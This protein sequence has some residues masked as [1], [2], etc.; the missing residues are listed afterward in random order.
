MDLAARYLSD[1][2]HTHTDARTLTPNEH[3]R[4]RT[5]SPKILRPPFFPWPFLRLHL[6]FV[7]L[8]KKLT[9]GVIRSFIFFRI[10]LLF[11]CI[12]ICIFCLVA[13]LFYIFIFSQIYLCWSLQDPGPWLSGEHNHSRHFWNHTFPPNKG[14]MSSGISSPNQARRK[15][16][17]LVVP[18][19]QRYDRQ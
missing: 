1:L 15:Q 17:C 5:H 13:V 3:A 2:T 18:T 6:S 7:T 19:F 14:P 12:V 16:I 11:F 4:T 9:C 10:F 8:W